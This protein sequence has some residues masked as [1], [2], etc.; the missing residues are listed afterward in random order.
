VRIEVIEDVDAFAS[1]A[2]DLL[3]ADEA[4]HTALLSGLQAARRA[5]ARGETLPDGWFTVVVH[6]GKRVA[7]AARRWRRTWVLSLGPADALAALGCWAA[8]RGEFDG[9]VGPD[10]AVCA[11]ERGTGLTAHTHLTLPLM[12]LDGPPRL[13]R[14]AAGVLRRATADDLP[15]LLAWNEAFRVE[16]RIPM[17]A[18]QVAADVR[19]PARLDSQYLWIGED[20][21]PV[22]M[23]GGQT[24]AP[25]GARIGPVYTPPVQRG[26]G[27]GGAMVA[28]LS[29]L[30]L[31]QGARCVFL[32]TDA[33]NPTSNALYQRI[34]FVPIGRHL[35]RLLPN[36]APAA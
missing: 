33:S 32:F 23:I 9:F 15:L 12:R 25:S 13:P 21:Q 17:T 6:D 8:A 28:T 3:A 19:R 34:R 36:A 22:G 10:D 26:R 29:E 5:A 27:I 20:A 7:A 30:L 1:A 11:F 16:A 4:H 2:G 31:A 14:P 18:A 35:H 24:I